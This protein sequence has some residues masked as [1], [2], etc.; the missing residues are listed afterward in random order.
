VRR[1]IPLTPVIALAIVIAAVGAYLAMIHPKRSESAR[2]DD[3]IAALEARLTAA[4]AQRRPAP[5]IAIDVADLF[6][7]AKAMPNEDDMPGV[8][9][10]LNSLASATGIEFISIAPGQP[11]SSAS[12]RVLPVT[13]KFEGSY[14]DLAD[15]LFRLRNLVSVEDGTL[16]ARGRLYTL[17]SLDFHEGE[18]GFPDVEALFTVSAYVFRPSGSDD[19]S[20][21]HAS[22]SAATPTPTA[23][24]SPPASPAPGLSPTQP[25]PPPA[26]PAPAPAT[27]TASSVGSSQAAPS[28]SSPGGTP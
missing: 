19:G 18:R 27:G 22:A 12:G 6:A 10:E 9:L 2:L 7:L 4:E 16:E 26:P 13:L 8:L 14:Y 11:V 25:S 1:Q 17:D 20:D 28:A 5:E 21:D 24:A 23:G 3:E 15:F